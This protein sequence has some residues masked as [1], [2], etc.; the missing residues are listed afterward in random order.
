MNRK[1]EERM[2]TREYMKDEKWKP[3]RRLRKVVNKDVREGKESGKRNGGIGNGGEGNER[4][5]EGEQ[6]ESGNNNWMRLTGERS[7]ERVGH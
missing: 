4:M 1:E 2:K 6:K 7:G 5:M 3:R